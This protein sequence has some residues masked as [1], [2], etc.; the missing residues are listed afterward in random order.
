MS[1][2]FVGNDWSQDHHDVCVMDEAGTVLAARRFPDGLA[3]LAGMHE[4]LAEHADGSS[5]EV[6]IGIETDRGLWVQALA[7]AGP[8][9]SKVVVQVGNNGTVTDEELEAIAEAAGD[10]DLYFLTVRVPRSWEG[11]VN[12]TLR[13]HA[14]DLGATVIDWRGRSEGQLAWFY[15]DGIHLNQTGQQAY[16]DVIEQTIGA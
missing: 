2:I 5:Q 6:V 7:A 15:D 11:D 12:Q 1:M 14:E 9:G 8:L 13:D 10:A 4:L 16:A 3:G